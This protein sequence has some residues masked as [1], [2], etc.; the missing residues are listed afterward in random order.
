MTI[1]VSITL[2]YTKKVSSLYMYLYREYKLIDIFCALFGKVL[3]V[4]V[5]ECFIGCFEI[6]AITEMLPLP[7][8]PRSPSKLH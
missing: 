8:M 6:A 5:N 7:N 1:R 4:G 2:L 3:C